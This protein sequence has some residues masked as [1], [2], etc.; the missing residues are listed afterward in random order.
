[1]ENHG[2]SPFLLLLRFVLVLVHS[3]AHFQSCAVV[4]HIIATRLTYRLQCRN[5]A[6]GRTIWSV[7]IVNMCTACRRDPP[8]CL[9]VVHG[10]HVFTPVYLS[11]P[12]FSSFFLIPFSP[13]SLALHL[14]SIICVISII[15][16]VMFE[17][18]DG[19]RTGGDRV[20][21]IASTNRPFDLDEAVL[22]RLPRRILVDLPDAEVREEAQT[23]ILF[24]YAYLF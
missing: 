14:P 17:E 1:M 22:R 8:A 3:S 16:L 9:C 11:V 15:Y 7:W 10:I 20:V 5:G 21:V 23:S 4:P 19:L 2:R 13:L 12:I 24:K 6:L 18:W